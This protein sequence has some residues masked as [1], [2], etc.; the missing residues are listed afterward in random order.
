L[1]VVCDLLRRDDVSLLTL[2]GPGGVGKTRLALSAADAVEDDFPDGVTVVALAAVTDPSL[3]APAI[4]QA[5][6]VREAGEEP[7]SHQLQAVL[8]D[9]HSLLVLDN[10]EQVVETAPLVADLVADCPG[11]TVLVTSRGRL[12]LSIEREVPVSP[13][14]VPDV[15]G[16]KP[17]SPDIE[18][19]EAVRLFVARAQAVKPDFVLTSQNVDAVAAI[20]HRLDGLPL[21]IELAAARVKVLPPAALLPRRYSPGSTTGCR[22]SPGEDAIS[23]RGSRRC[24]MPS[25]GAMACSRR[26]SR[27]CFVACRSSP[28]A[29][30]SMPPRPWPTLTRWLRS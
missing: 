10:F 26:R 5:L 11:L 29:A 20:C 2:T 24:A 18:G 28:A 27:R 1:A 25:P 23:R 6:G 17:A 3:V 14:T 16:G 7:L 4:A 8:R 21:A 9:S 13:L 12:R 30:H 22:S 15:L 19:A